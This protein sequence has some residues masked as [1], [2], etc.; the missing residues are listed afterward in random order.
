[1]RKG[2][3]KRSCTR[4]GS[5]VENRFS[6]RFAQIADKWRLWLL[7]EIRK[8]QPSRQR[9]LWAANVKTNTILGEVVAR[10]DA[11]SVGFCGFL[12][13]RWVKRGSIACRPVARHL[14]GRLQPF[15]ELR[16]FGALPIFR[17]KATSQARATHI[18]GSE[19]SVCSNPKNK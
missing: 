16:Y 11:N 17:D 4:K 3:Q 8:P 2:R 19:H 15:A 12:M 13:S 18:Y 6:D 9:P 1:V 5:P 10:L 7:V 14:R